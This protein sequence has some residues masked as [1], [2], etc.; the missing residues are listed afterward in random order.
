LETVLLVEDE[1]SLR[2]VVGNTL[3]AKGYAVLDAPDSNTAIELAQSFESPI[4]LL[5]TDVILPGISGRDMAALLQ[6]SRPSM[7]VIYMSGYTDEFIAEHGIMDPQIVLLEKPFR[8]S[9]LLQN[10]REV[11]DR[12]AADLKTA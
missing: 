9:A 2:S 1:G 6:I 4:D 10:I 7:K 8:M 12:P 3:R 5:L 11:L